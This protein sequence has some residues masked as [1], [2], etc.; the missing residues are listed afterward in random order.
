MGICSYFQFMVR[1]SQKQH[2]INFS[3]TIVSIF[4]DCLKKCDVV[5]HFLSEFYQKMTLESKKHLD[6]EI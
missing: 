5:T 6:P 1:L 4:L 2:F 3:I